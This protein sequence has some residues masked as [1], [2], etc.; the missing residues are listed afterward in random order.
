MASRIPGTKL[1]QARNI[2]SMRLIYVDDSGADIQVV[3]VDGSREADSQPHSVIS[4]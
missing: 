3:R 2:V 1:M 4:V